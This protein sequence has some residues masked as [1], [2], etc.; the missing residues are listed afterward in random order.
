MKHT[1]LKF[2]PKEWVQSGVDLWV[3]PRQNLTFSEHGH[4]V[5]QNKV[6]F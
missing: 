4:V 5:Y 3:G 6:S 1:K 2:S